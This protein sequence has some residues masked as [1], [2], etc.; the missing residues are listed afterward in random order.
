MG[1][2]DY[3]ISW[4]IESRLEDDVF[5]TWEL[6]GWAGA[7][8]GLARAKQITDLQGFAET[9]RAAI[10]LRIGDGEDAGNGM[11]QGTNINPSAMAVLNDL[12]RVLIGD[13]WTTNGRNHGDFALQ[14]NA[15][16]DTGFKPEFRDGGNQVQHAMAGIY[17]QC[18]HWEVAK[19]AY[20]QEDEDADL[21]LYRATF[22]IGDMLSSGTPIGRLPGLI[23]SRL[24]A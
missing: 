5:P 10:R 13:G 24:A 7:W 19:F 12:R 16:L 3:M 18:L 22:Q 11:M 17:L 15:F 21:A 23:L 2:M 6:K 20:W 1:T 14:Y 8:A 4:D 9:V